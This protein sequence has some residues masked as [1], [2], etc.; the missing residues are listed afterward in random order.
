MTNTTA[1]RV[2]RSGHT[3]A[4]WRVVAVGHRVFSASRDS[5]VRCWSGPNFRCCAVLTGHTDE[6]LDLVVHH[7]GRDDGDTALFTSSADGTCRMW[8]MSSVPDDV[9]AGLDPMGAVDV[10]ADAVADVGERV[11]H[12]CMAGVC[13]GT[14][15]PS[16]CGAVSTLL[17]GPLYRQVFLTRS[18]H[19]TNMMH[20]LLVLRAHVQVP[21][22][23]SMTMEMSLHVCSS[24]ALQAQSLN[25]VSVPAPHRNSVRSLLQAL[26]AESPFSHDDGRPCNGIQ[27]RTH[28][29]A[30]Q[31][32][33]LLKT[34]GLD[35]QPQTT[36]TETT[37]EGPALGVTRVLTC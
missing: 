17:N 4:V 19:I 18:T 8:R 3:D 27:G 13:A 29:T 32:R 23:V 24:A 30:H 14:Q 20:S 22:G 6:V 31:S 21:M 7:R 11:M 1:Q 33:A 35:S 5:T 28:R 36:M 16:A 10:R 25:G 2:L 37:R 15:S 9:A 26:L 34:V 12:F